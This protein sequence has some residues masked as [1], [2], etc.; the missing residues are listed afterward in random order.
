MELSSQEIN[1][2]TGA[3][4]DAAMKVHTF[5]GPGLLESSYEACLAHELNLRGLS[6]STQYPIDLVYEGLR[7]EVG[8]RADL[9]VDNAVIVELKA[10]DK[11]LPVHEA[12]LIS[13]LR[14][15]GFRV[16]LLINFHEE[17]LRDGIRRRVNRF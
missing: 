17:H 3:I 11:I 8:Y 1:D 6:I 12:Q 7:L 15:T 14:L 2:R 4:I 16:G 10:V 13:Y 5:L 9:L